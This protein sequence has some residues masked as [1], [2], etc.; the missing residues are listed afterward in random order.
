MVGAGSAAGSTAKGVCFAPGSIGK[1]SIPAMSSRLTGSGSRAARLGVLLLLAHSMLIF[2]SPVWAEMPAY[3]V[4]WDEARLSVTATQAPLAKILAEIIERTG[5]EARGLP[6]FPDVASVEFAKLPLREGLQKL[7][8]GKNYLFLDQEAA[9][10]TKAPG[11]LLFLDSSPAGILP[12]VAVE[13]APA[14]ESENDGS[15]VPERLARLEQVI[16]ANTPDLN[17]KL[18]TATQDDEPLIRELAYR[19][20]YRRGDTTALDV[21]RRDAR[22]ENVDVRRTALELLSELAGENAVDLLAE[23]ASDPS[24]DIRQIA[25]ENLTKNA[26]GVTIIKEKLHDSDPEVR[27]GALEWLASLG[28]EFAEEAA[29]VTLHDPDERV[30]FRAEAIR[31]EFQAMQASQ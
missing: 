17:D 20:L 11:V 22:S 3:Q 29:M 25:M 16:G 24:A 27:M 10:G 26:Q 4:E 5:L 28:N 2:C 30:R 9:K 7:L 21:L 15:E 19:E 8:V 14:M 31:Q 18:Y 1:D 12:R 6:A 23:A 13:E